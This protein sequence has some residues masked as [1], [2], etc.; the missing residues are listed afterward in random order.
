[1]AQS[2]AGGNVHTPPLDIWDLLCMEELSVYKTMARELD[3]TERGT[4][5]HVLVC[6]CVWGEREGGQKKK[7]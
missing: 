6:L 1:M 2:W 4:I 5:V 3:R 7:Q